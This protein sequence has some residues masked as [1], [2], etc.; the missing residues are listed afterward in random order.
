M[1]M[2]VYGRNPKQNKPMSDFPTYEKW[3]KIP[4]GKRE[5]IKWEEEQKQFYTVIAKSIFGENWSA[6]NT[7]QV[8]DIIEVMLG[9]K[10]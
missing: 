9:I 5:K 2:D 4:Y 7:K 1:G 3:D 6:H 8:Q 10:K